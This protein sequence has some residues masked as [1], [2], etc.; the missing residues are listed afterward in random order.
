MTDLSV[1][2]ITAEFSADKPVMSF[3]AN[4]AHITFDRSSF[5]TF[6]EVAGADRDP[7]ALYGA[8]LKDIRVTDVQ[9]YYEE[10]YTYKDYSTDY[11]NGDFHIRFKLRINKVGLYFFLAEFYNVSCI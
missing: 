6:W 3:A 4:K 1:G 5:T 8:D 2:I 7:L 10:L 11:F 9:P